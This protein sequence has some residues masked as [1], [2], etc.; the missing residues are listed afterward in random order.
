M[1]VHLFLAVIR[2][3]LHILV[4]ESDQ[5][6]VRRCVDWMNFLCE[7]R[8]E[9]YIIQRFDY[10]WSRLIEHSFDLCLRNEMSWKTEFLQVCGNLKNQI[11]TLGI[12]WYESSVD[13]RIAIWFKLR[14]MIFIR[15]P[16]AIECSENV[17]TGLSGS[18]LLIIIFL[19]RSRA[20]LRAIIYS[21]P[22]RIKGFGSID[23]MTNEL[24]VQPSKSLVFE[25]IT[26]LIFLHLVVLLDPLY[27]VLEDGEV[28]EEDCE[29]WIGVEVTV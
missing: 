21:C 14:L 5:G 18:L 7:I 11:S 25:L 10:H 15:D 28:F 27:D 23:L 19:V 17:V 22:Y 29:R 2:I 12:I 24:V 13:Q 8:V 4:F 16:I 9:Q 6:D 3:D 20:Y 26:I 1:L